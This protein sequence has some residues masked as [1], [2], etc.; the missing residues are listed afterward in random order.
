MSLSH[1]HGTAREFVRELVKG[2][3]KIRGANDVVRNYVLQQIEPEKRKLCED[4]AFIGNRR[5]K[6]D[7]ESGEPVR[8]DNE[9]L[10]AEIVDITNLAAGGGR[11]AGE[12]GLF[13]DFHCRSR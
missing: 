5:W 10:V 9:Q 8:G 4:A 1:D 6:D 2:R 11:E 13:Y 7:V 12:L 3:R